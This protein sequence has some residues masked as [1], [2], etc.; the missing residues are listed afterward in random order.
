MNSK[1]VYTD[2][3]LKGF[4]L[5]AATKVKNDALPTISKLLCN[6][7]L[8]DHSGKPVSVS[9]DL[10]EF[11]YDKEIFMQAKATRLG[12]ANY[13]IE[14]GVGLL[15]QLSLIAKSIAAD[16]QVLR[17]RTK[18]KLLDADIRKDGRE[19]ALSDFIFHY[20]LTFVM[21]HEV[22]HV[23]LGHLDWLNKNSQLNVIE[24]FGQEKFCEVNCVQYQTLEGDADRQASLWTSAMIDYSISSNPFLRYPILTD[25]FHD[26]GY[27]YGALFV[28]LDS[29][30]KEISQSS[31]K[32]PKADV[33]LGIALSFVE[34]YLI[35]FHKDS[36]STL[37]QQVYAG[38][39]KALATILHAE[40]RPFDVSGVAN[41]MAQNGHRIDAMKL[42]S[43]QHSVTNSLGGSFVVA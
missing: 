21:W 29:V 4:N 14:I 15:A 41:F 37:M 31:R 3:S 17:G 11:D 40:K 9:V 34:E 13:M 26:I 43:L 36:H 10:N 2:V 5:E 30:D 27:I 32:H 19:K 18:S 38:G 23:A 35:K 7:T 39:F 22:A 42:R 8:H 20:M 25:A 1:I 16:K 33:R 28:F 12:E 6:L 24:E